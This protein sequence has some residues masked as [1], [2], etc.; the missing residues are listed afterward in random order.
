MKAIS[1][2]TIYEIAYEKMK[3]II[4][5]RHEVQSKTKSCATL[6]N[7]TSSLLQPRYPRMH[8]LLRPSY[9]NHL[10]DNLIR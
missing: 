10:L 8:F 7:S 4:S 9:L 6:M 2:G 5:Y 1:S 3:T